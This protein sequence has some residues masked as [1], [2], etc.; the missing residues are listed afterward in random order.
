MPKIKASYKS[1]NLEFDL[2]DENFA[3]VLAAFCADYGQQY[4]WTETVLRPDPNGQSGD[5]ISIPNP[6]TPFRFWLR[7]NLQWTKEVVIER[8]EAELTAQKQRELNAERAKLR[9]GGFDLVTMTNA[10]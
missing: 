4:G 9:E 10:S 2:N 3:A 7:V 5:L 1:E 6:E 8:A